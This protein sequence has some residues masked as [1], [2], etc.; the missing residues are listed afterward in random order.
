MKHLTKTALATAFVAS[1]V[2][3]AGCQR[4]DT[5]VVASNQ[6]TGQ[7]LDSGLGELPHYRDW[8]DPTGKSLDKPVIRVA[9]ADKRN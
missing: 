6:V 4:A 9:G 8:T 1:A 3:L 5:F 2:L 7:K